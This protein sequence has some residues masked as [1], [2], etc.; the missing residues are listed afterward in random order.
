MEPSDEMIDQLFRE[1]ILRAR[2][3]PPE[4]KLSD[5]PRLFDR[6]CRTM[7]DGIRTQFPNATEEDV[8]RI[9][10]ERLEIARKLEEQP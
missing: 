4:E 2:A 7:K 9:L 1:R 3:T 8:R 10:I 6:L 5:G